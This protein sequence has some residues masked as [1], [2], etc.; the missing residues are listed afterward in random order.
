MYLRRVLVANRGEIALRIIRACHEEGLEAVAV[1]S[2]ADRSSPHVRAADL[3]VPIGPAP[4]AESYLRIDALLAAARATV[5]QAVHP[6]Y[7]FLAERAAFAEAVEQAGLIFIGPPSQ[8]IRAMGDKTEARRRM[9]AAG[10]PVVPGGTAAV[11]GHR[12]AFA[13]AREL[14][15]PVLVK[16]AAGGGGR[17]M[18]LV[19]DPAGLRPALVA[20]A[21]EALKA[22]GDAAV[23]LEKL[24]ERPRH[25]E[26]QVLA[27]FAKTVHLGERECS[28]QRRH[29]KLLEE[30]PSVAVSPHLR[31]AMG[32]AAVAAAVAVRYRGVGTCEFLLAPDGSYYFL[33]M[34]TRIQVEHPVTDIVLFL[35][36]LG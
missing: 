18:R 24:I 25:V 8:A 35:V 26:I 1:Y 9:R 10:V 16:A 32:E 23:Y 22:F 6:G 14:G 30:A 13:L 12:E 33:E 19:K 3:A 29:Q 36:V 15:Y 20:A 27:D 28:I 11:T 7:G 34:N 5:A 31:R 2:E 4:P 17:G 21:S